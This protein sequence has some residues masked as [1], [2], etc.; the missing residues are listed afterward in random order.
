MPIFEYICKGCN[1]HFEALVFGSQQAA[2]PACHGTS[3]DPQISSFSVG[4]SSKAASSCMSGGCE[5]GACGMPG[6]P[7]MCC[8][9]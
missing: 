4:H 5:S 1:K 6:G 8:E 2:C 3:L 7:G 9:N